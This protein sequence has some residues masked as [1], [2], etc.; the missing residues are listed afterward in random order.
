MVGGKNRMMEKVFKIN[1]PK[2]QHANLTETHTRVAVS[3]VLLLF[4]SCTLKYMLIITTE[5]HTHT[6]D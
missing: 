3:I 6:R 2:L 4:Q 5:N 1:I